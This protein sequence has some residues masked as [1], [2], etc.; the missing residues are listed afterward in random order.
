MSTIVTKNTDLVRRTMRP[1][2]EDLALFRACFARNSHGPRSMESLRWQYA[3]SVTGKTFVDLALADGESRVAAIYAALPGYFR[4]EGQRRLSLQSLDTLTDADFRGRGL[5]VSLA[6]ETF[7]RA[8]ADDAA[9]IYG[10]PNGNSAHGF[11]KKLGW[12]PLDPLPMLLRPLRTGY[13]AKKAPARYRS[14]AERLPDLPLSL[15]VSLPLLGREV[16]EVTRATVDAR[17]NDLWKDFSSG[18]GVTL[19]RDDAYLRW[20]LFDKPEENYVVY[21]LERDGRVDAFIAFVVKEKHGGRI[22]YVMELLHRPG[23]RASGALLLSRAVREMAAARAD[24]ILAWCFSHSPNFGAYA[25]N[26]FF[27]LPEK[28]RPIELHAGVRAF[29][30]KIDA[31]V[32]ERSNWYMSYLDSD[33]V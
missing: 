9:L 25:L 29:D 13:F 15:P 18:I 32:R 17:L 19:D 30:T 14:I 23:D 11:F 2:D 1:T 27:P 26:G 6:K 20:R 31:I 21:T 12:T 4:I 10:Y 22:G 5:F 33:T 24:A 8:A 3:S 16:R 28:M 7:R